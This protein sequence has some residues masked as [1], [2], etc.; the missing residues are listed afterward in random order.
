MFTTYIVDN[1]EGNENRETFPSYAAAES[2]AN[3]LLSFFGSLD[4]TGPV[5]VVVGIED[6]FTEERYPVGT[7]QTP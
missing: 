2:A 7:V 4:R 6:E 5:D 1:L 3:T